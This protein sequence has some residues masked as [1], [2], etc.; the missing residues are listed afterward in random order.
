MVVVLAKAVAVAGGGVVVAVE[1]L[2]WCEVRR[3]R[4]R[5]GPYLISAALATWASRAPG[6]LRPP[7]ARHATCTLRPHSLCVPVP[8]MFVALEPW[9][10]RACSDALFRAA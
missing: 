8:G 3:T 4:A 10:R 6:M 9:W 5:I 7:G 1:V 2:E